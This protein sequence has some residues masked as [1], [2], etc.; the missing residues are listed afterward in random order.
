VVAVRHLTGDQIIALVEIVSPVNESTKNAIDQMVKKA[1]EFLDR[2]I[3]LFI[4]DLFPT[5]RNDP[6][7]IDGSSTH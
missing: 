1:A 5:G 6:L 4:L 7:G 2:G 3:H